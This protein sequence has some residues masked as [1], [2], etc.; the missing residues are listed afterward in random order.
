MH[1]NEENCIKECSQLWELDDTKVCLHYAKLLLRDSAKW[2]LEEFMK[3]W[4]RTTPAG[5]EP[6]IEMLRGEA[7]VEKLGPESWL[8]LYSIS[9]LPTKPADRF[10]ALFKE[11]AKWEWDDLEPYLR[12]QDLSYWRPCINLFCIM[13][14]SVNSCTTMADPLP[15]FSCKLNLLWFLYIS[16]N[17]DKFGSGKWLCGLF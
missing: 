1:R 9:S 7:L 12:Y 3:E 2:K 4:Q 16:V 8:Q 17:F 14:S 11:R 10:S 13:V 5:I 15:P 6:S